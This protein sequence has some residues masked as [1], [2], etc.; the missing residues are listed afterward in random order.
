M[1]NELPDEVSVNTVSFDDTSV[2]PP[3]KHIFVESRISWFQ[4]ADDLPIHHGYGA[5]VKPIDHDE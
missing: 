2:F 3:R 1:S 4:T 5:L